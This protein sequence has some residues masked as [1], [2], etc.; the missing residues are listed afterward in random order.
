[1]VQI[2]H[3]YVTTGKAIALI[4]CNFVSKEMSL[5]LNTL[6]RLV[7]EVFSDLLK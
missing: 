5:L 1:M 2:S 7:I 4:R 3:P 6:S